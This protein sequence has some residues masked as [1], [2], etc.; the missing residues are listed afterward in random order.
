MEEIEIRSLGEFID[1]QRILED[2][3]YYRG[4]NDISYKLLPSIGRFNF[5]SDGTLFQFEQDIFNDFKRKAYSYL[6]GYE[7]PKNDFEWLFLA[8]HYGLP[9]RLLDWTYSP[10]IA[11]FFAVE[12]DKNTDC[13]VYESF[14]HR[15]VD[16]I[17]SDNPFAIPIISEV[18]PNMDN[19][20]YQNQNGL[21]KI[22]PNPREESDNY[23]T[24]KY[25]IRKENKEFFRWKLRKIGISKTL[26][27]PS[28]DSLSYDIIQI[29]KAKYS[30]AI[31]SE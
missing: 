26:V 10:V 11:L 7:I 27:Y 22:Y 12:N 24:K 25:I 17:S 16:S 6:K 2:V 9:T 30:H 4:H 29:T 13:C 21:F 5:N 3:N 14:P 20:R 23:I 19:V 18:I 1:Q 31:I 8:Q 28:L 15:I